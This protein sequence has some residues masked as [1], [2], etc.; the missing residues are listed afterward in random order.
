MRELSAEEIKERE[1]ASPCFGVP[2][3]NNTISLVIDFRQ[4]NRVLKRKEY[5][6]PTIDK[7]FQ[8][9]CGFTFASVIDLNMGY[10]SI[11]L[12]EQTQKL[13]T[14]VTTFGFFECCVLPMGIKPATDIFQSRM[15]GIFQPMKEN[16]PNPYIDNIFHGKGKDFDKH[17]TIL[18][19]ILNHLKQ[20]GM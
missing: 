7:M 8:N 6:L 14:I 17:L 11:P 18:D 13:L 10:L 3:K 1:W 9:I 15:V 19:N 5:P 20:A 2:K 4:L 12:T 16:R